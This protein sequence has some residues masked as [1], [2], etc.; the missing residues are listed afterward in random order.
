MASASWLN[1]Q[2]RAIGLGQ[3]VSEFASD[4]S[5]EQKRSFRAQKENFSSPKDTDVITAIVEIHEVAARNQASNVR[6]YVPR[7]INFLKAVQEFASLQDDTPD[8]FLSWR[9]G[10]VWLLVRLTFTV[11]PFHGY[12]HKDLIIPGVLTGIGWTNLHSIDIPTDNPDVSSYIDSET[13]RLLNHGELT[14]ADPTLELQI[15]SALTTAAKGNF[16]RAKRSMQLLCA[17]KTDSD[18]VRL[19][20][21]FREDFN[22]SDTEAMQS[23]SPTAPAPIAPSGFTDSAYASASLID[24]NKNTNDGQAVDESLQGLDDPTI[25]DSATIYSDVSRTTFYKEQLYIQEL[26]KDLY[27]KISFQAV[28]LG[29]DHRV[30]ISATL[31][32]LL[33]AFALKIGYCAT[34]QM[35]RDVMAFVH[36]HRSEITEAFL[37]IC[38]SQREMEPREIACPT[39]V[40]VEPMDVYPGQME[41][42]RTEIQDDHRSMSLNERMALWEQSEDWEQPSIVEGLDNL[43]LVEAEE[44]DEYEEADIWVAAYRDFA[45]GTEAYSWLMTQLQRNMDSVLEEPTAIQLIRD[46]VLSSVPSP[47]MISRSV[48]SESCS[49]LFDLD[50]DI[51]EF[52][53][54]QEFSKSPDEVLLAVITL[55][56]SPSDAQAS[57]CTQFLKQTWPTT[58]DMILRLIRGLLRLEGGHTHEYHLPDHTR[59]TAWINGSKVMVQANGSAASISET[60]EQLAWLGAALRSSPYPNGLSYCTPSIRSMHQDP[61]MPQAVVCV[62]GFE[63]EQLLEPPDNSNGH[64]WHGIFKDPTLVKGFPILPKVERNTGLEIPLNIMAGLARANRVDQF[65]GKVYIK[66]FS[67][68]LVPTKQSKEVVYWHLIYNEDGSR[69]SYLDDNLN[70]DVLAGTP[71]L[72]AHRHV[73]GWCS[74][75]RFYSGSSQAQYHVRHS[76]LPKPHPGCALAGTM[77]TL[78]RMITGGHS[79][80]LGIKDSPIHV[81]RNGY[82]PRLKWISSKFFLLWDEADK[83]GWLTNGTSAL[84]YVVRASLA[85]DSTDK[86]HSVFLFKAGDLQESTKPFTADS[87]ID[88]LINSKNLA[89]KLYPEKNGFITLRDRVDQYYNLLEKMLDHQAYITSRYTGS[90]EG[91]PRKNL[92]G[93]D[94][95]D[96]SA[97]RDPLYPRLVTLEPAGKG[98]VDLTR[99]LQAVTLAG[100]GFGELIRPAGPALCDYWSQL[101]RHRYLLACSISDMEDVVRDHRSSES[102][103]TRLSDNLI[104]HNAVDISGKCQCGDVAR[105]HGE[106]VHVAFPSALSH[107]LFPNKSPIK[108]SGAAVFGHNPGFSWTWGDTGPPTQQQSIQEIGVRYVLDK[109]DKDSGIG[110]SLGA[111]SSESHAEPLPSSSISRAPLSLRKSNTTP[112]SVRNIYSQSEYT[113]GILCALAVEL[114]A[115]RALFD[116]RHQHLPSVIGDNN[117]YALG[118]M[119]QHMVVATSLPAGEYGTNAVA[120]A[121]SDMKRSF[122]SIQFCLLVGIAGGA[123]SEDNDIR[124]GDV[125][126]SLPTQT[127]PGVI[128]YDLGKENE[129]SEFEVTGVLQR[130]PRILTNAISKIRSDPDIGVDALKPHLTS[131]VESLPAYGNPGQELDVLSR[132]ACTRRTCKPDCTHLEQR[133]PRLTAEPMI[134]HGLVASANR[135]VKD[136]TLR[137]QLSRKHG[138][139]CFEME[140][141]GVMNSAGCLVIRGICDYS[142]AQKNNIW[143]NYAAAVAAAYTKLLLS[144]VAVNNDLGGGNVRTD[145]APMF[146][147]RRMNSGNEGCD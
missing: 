36:R 123:P 128:Q 73:L 83:R 91:M 31:P 115:V 22:D 3:A 35:H 109:A 23:K 104:W 28:D 7:M 145:G 67:T 96:L 55:T 13:S 14:I 72:T 134:H 117:Q 41:I 90:L 12:V 102:D 50:W 146:K 29:Q 75:A 16:L 98:W 57:N 127:Y 1:P 26:A 64:C 92:E 100:S 114:K 106:P 129:G 118:E 59:L 108:L 9:T 66:G 60:G 94:F 143:Q 131:I 80:E 124:L 10:S 49:V 78:G 74:E 61:E 43:E 137:D 27:N 85:Y 63:L 58:G 126:V 138:V 112:P 107:K 44:E 110:E 45:P 136:A 81:A 147:K 141:A 93:W 42:E 52:F 15:R 5:E 79:F 125:V 69:I 76:E 132:A 144:A 119:A 140:A 47:H 122:T 46:Q 113:V 30:D 37:D 62:I 4:L 86:F 101:P 53:D 88:V 95:E 133:L 139:L 33:K 135:V 89:L 17:H 18:I 120:S 38:L 70:R 68:M 25:D 2:S 24:N 32:R 111:S 116:Q 11:C 21:D 65:N 105:H 56:G 130:P 34:T 71:D 20:A 48:S 99:D 6:R 19:L 97:N 8:K 121:V 40:E 84:L 39:P 82:I 87:A 51:I 103:H 142:D 77:I 54:S